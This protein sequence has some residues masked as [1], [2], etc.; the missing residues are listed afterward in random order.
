MITKHPVLSSEEYGIVVDLEAI[1]TPDPI[2]VA[3]EEIHSPFVVTL[4]LTP[5]QR[6]RLTRLAEDANQSL[7]AYVSSV[8]LE[9]L[10][11]RV[12]RPTITGPSKL[13]H[14]PINGI[15]S[16]KGPIGGLVTRG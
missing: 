7:E 15:G 9:D 11:Q 14:Q 8:V 10:Q 6:T 3:I 5:S 2:E 4:Q 12:G 16:I 1:E 13:A